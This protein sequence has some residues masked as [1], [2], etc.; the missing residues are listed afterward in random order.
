MLVCVAA[1]PSRRVSA[2]GGLT[3]TAFLACCAACEH[4]HLQPTIPETRIPFGSA[5]KALA[6]SGNIRHCTRTPDMNDSGLYYR[7]VLKHPVLT[8]ILVRSQLS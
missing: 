1:A 7:A 4:E 3:H 5:P 2:S 6:R 8:A